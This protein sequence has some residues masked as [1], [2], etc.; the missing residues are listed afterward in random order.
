MIAEGQA[1]GDLVDRDLFFVVSVNMTG[2]GAYS[3]PSKLV[4]F[5]LGSL[6]KMFRHASA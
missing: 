2:H 1:E 4:F 6:L 3:Y 5:L